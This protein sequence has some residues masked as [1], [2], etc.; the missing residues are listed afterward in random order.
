MESLAFDHLPEHH[1]SA[2]QPRR[3]NG[4]DEKLRSIGVGP[5]IRHRQEPWASVQNLE[6][7][8]REFRSAEWIDPALS[9]ID[10]KRGAKYKK[11][12]KYKG[13]PENSLVNERN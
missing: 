6:V 10:E 9:K 1:V 7:L 13:R 2:I 3:R 12:S 11:Q 5:S 8:V 4:G